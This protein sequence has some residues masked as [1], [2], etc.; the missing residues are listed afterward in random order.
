M[1]VLHTPSE[2]LG[3]FKYAVMAILFSVEEFNVEL[4]EG[5]Q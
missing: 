4:E 2:D 3:G 1:N 5:E